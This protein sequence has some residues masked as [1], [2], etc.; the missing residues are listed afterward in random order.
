MP[1]HSP[2]NRREVALALFSLTTFVLF[3]NLE[4]SFTS[5][6]TEAN[7][8]SAD[9]SSVNWDEVIYGNWTR[10]EQLVAENAQKHPLLEESSDPTAVSFHAHVFGSVGVNDG[11][12]DWGD[13][14]PTTTVLKHVPG[15]R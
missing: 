10:Q 8:K 5:R 6:T 1:W 9:S 14:I 11:I 13:E 4:T 3:Y 15:A 12:L 2:P 7:N